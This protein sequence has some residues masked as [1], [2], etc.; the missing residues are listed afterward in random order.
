MAAGRAGGKAACQLFGWTRLCAGHL[1]DC[2][3][4]NGR[5]RSSSSIC[6]CCCC[7]SR[8]ESD[9]A[10]HS[11]VWMRAEDGTGGM[12]LGRSTRDAQSRC[13]RPRRKI[14]HRQFQFGSAWCVDEERERETRPSV[15]AQVI[16]G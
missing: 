9:F 13:G 6:C 5:W 15:L 4:G 8:L 1:A 11:R 7:C 14:S 2:V 12:K 3:A 10:Q 16:D